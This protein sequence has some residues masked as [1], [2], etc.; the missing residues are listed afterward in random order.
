MIVVEMLLFL[1]C[2]CVVGVMVVL[3]QETRIYRCEADG[4]P[5]R[6]TTAYLRVC[7]CVCVCVYALLH[8]QTSTRIAATHFDADKLRVQL[9]I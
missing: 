8:C 6:T 5:T 1:F 2:R 7:V 3:R 9:V 4:T